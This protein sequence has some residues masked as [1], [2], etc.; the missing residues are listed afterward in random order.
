MPRPEGGDEASAPPAAEDSTGRS[1]GAARP[2]RPECSSRCAGMSIPYGAFL[3]GDG[4]SPSAIHADAC[5]NAF[6]SAPPP[7]D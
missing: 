4:A 6:Y 3:R 7:A 5:A 1:V 2:G